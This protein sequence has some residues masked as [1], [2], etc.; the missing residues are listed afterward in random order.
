MDQSN[1]SIIPS[2]NLSLNST[3]IGSIVIRPVAQLNQRNST[4]ANVVQVPQ[5]SFNDSISSTARST[6]NT[7]NSQADSHFG[8]E[9]F[10]P[11]VKMEVPDEESGDTDFQKFTQSQD[12]NN[13]NYVGQF[14]NEELRKLPY[15]DAC[16]LKNILIREVINFSDK[17]LQRK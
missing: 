13:W 7:H 6:P 12:D 10:D 17:L 14:I 15:E 16:A 4:I 3:K 2:P 8:L 9:A 1:H 11:I 5:K